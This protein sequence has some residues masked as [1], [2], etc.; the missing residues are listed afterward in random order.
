M[1]IGIC[2]AQ[3]VGKT[4]L[5]NA[6]RS[7]R[8]LSDIRVCNE[9]TR[10]V[11]SYGIPINENGNDITQKLIMHEHIVNVFMYDEF[12]T[13]RTALDG[14]VYSH[15]LHENG[16]LSDETMTYVTN[17]FVKLKPCYDI[18]FY[19]KPEFD[20]QNDGIRSVDTMFRDRIVELFDQYIDTFRVPVINISGSVR[21][22]LDQTIAYIKREHSKKEMERDS[23]CDY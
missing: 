2:G 16:R 5:L 7:E 20:I 4:T 10:R 1:R 23:N 6:L 11:N 8:W 17:I 15:Y 19:I 3:S 21:E 13:D 18:L 12:I 22:R 9:V 14:V